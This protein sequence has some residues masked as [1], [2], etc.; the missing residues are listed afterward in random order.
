MI[1]RQHTRRNNGAVLGF[2]V[3][4]TMIICVLGAGIF[5]I[6]MAF[7][8]GNQMQ[9]AVQS[10]ALRSGQFIYK[11]DKF[12]V[13]GNKYKSQF[14]EL[15]EN[16]KFTL[17]NVNRVQ[18]KA[19]LISANYADMKAKGYDHKDASDHKDAV[20]SE[21]SQIAKQLKAEITNPNN[22]KKEFSTYANANSLRMLMPGTKVQPDSNFMQSAYMDADGKTE[23]N[24]WFKPQVLPSTQ[25]KAVSETPNGKFYVTGYKN[26]IDGI[27]LVP[28]RHDERTNLV[29]GSEFVPAMKAPVS[30]DLPNAWSVKGKA[31][32]RVGGEVRNQAMVQTNPR[33][34][35]EMR[36]YDGW[37]RIKLKAN[38]AKWYHN[39]MFKSEQQYSYFRQPKIASW[40]VTAGKA[41][42]TSMVGNETSLNLW[43]TLFPANA[44]GDGTVKSE[45]I[46]R[47]REMRPD[48]KDHELI[49]ALKTTPINVPSTGDQD[50][51]VSLNGNN[52]I[53]VTRWDPKRDRIRPDGSARDFTQSFFPEPNSSVTVILSKKCLKLFEFVTTKGTLKWKPGTGYDGCLGELE[54]SRTASV[55]VK[56]TAP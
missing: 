19:I 25:Q 54:V 46:H 11:D 41:T 52:E 31:Q 4:T 29:S 6:L 13:Q 38:S 12:K 2:I 10:G 7:A 17:G 9:H 39:G 53:A 45:L 51:Y 14:T 47:L 24:I 15:S 23:S 22:F 8:A 55:Y 48:L 35:F 56:A 26:Q 43:D 16:G 42:S 34:E 30:T 27:R 36:M 21:A 5:A 44:H 50:F 20:Q 37:V 33:E 1:A 28:F 40:A 32:T 49:K 3:A 18:A